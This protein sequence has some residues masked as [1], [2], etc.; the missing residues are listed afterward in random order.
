MIFSSTV[1]LFLFFPALLLIYYSPIVKNNI[2]IQ[3]VVL[4]IFSLFFY[5][6]GEPLFVFLMI[7]SILINYWLV[8]LMEKSKNKKS[9]MIIC[10]ILD[11][12]IL[13]VFKYSTFIIHNIFSYIG[14]Q[15][16]YNVA[17]PIGISFFTFQM[18]SYVWDVYYGKVLVLEKEICI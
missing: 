4:L 6:W 12:F 3:N 8:I 11:V 5:A 1:F 16:D 2:S 10:I 18:M 9:F 14:K 17:L 15:T 13:F 7:L